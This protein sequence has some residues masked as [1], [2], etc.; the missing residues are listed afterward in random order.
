MELKKR[1]LE[2]V[3]V[4]VNVYERGEE[5]EAETETEMGYMFKR[6]IIKK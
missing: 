2:F 1:F 5:R 6:M 3:Y 4:Y